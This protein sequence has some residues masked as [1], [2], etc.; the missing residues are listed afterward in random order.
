MGRRSL[1]GTFACVVT[2]LALFVGFLAVLLEAV[3]LEAVLLEAV[4]L[5]AVLLEAVLLE[6]MLLEAVLLEAML[7]EPMLFGGL[8]AARVIFSHVSLLSSPPLRSNLTECPGRC[9]RLRRVRWQAI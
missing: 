5:E 2:R 6:P 1:P 4:L 8:P 3:L 9:N 7:L